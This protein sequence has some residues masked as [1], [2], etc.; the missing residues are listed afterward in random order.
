MDDTPVSLD[1][2]REVQRVDSATN[3]H[4]EFASTQMDSVIGIFDMFVFYFFVYFYLIR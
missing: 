4:E 2:G 3:E 1:S